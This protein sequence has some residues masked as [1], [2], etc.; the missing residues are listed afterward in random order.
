MGVLA[1]AKNEDKQF[2]IIPKRKL[3]LWGTP[4]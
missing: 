4:N 2:W 1:Q 3:D